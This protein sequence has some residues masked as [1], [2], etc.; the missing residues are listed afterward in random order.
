VSLRSISRKLSRSVDELRNTSGA[1]YTY[2]PLEYARVPHEAYLKAFGEGKKKVLLLGMNPGPFGMAQTGV[3]F[4]DVVM[5]RDYLGIRGKV[6]VPALTHE[7]RP[8]LGFDCL[9]REVSGTRLW[10]LAQEHFPQAKDFFQTFFVANY[11]PLVFMEEGAKNLTPDKL[12]KEYRDELYHVCDNAVRAT[13]EE[14]CPTWVLGVGAFAQKRAANALAGYDVK[15]GTILHPSPASP[16]ANQGWSGQ[17]KSQLKEL[18]ISLP[19]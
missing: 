15:I 19:G 11:C 12:P 13:V 14:L 4:G 18:G 8:I 5:V 17:V 3:P 2:N 16:R 7:K 10:G 1:A 6:K 9:R